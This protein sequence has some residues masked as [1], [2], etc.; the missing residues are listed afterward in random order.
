MKAIDQT[1]AVTLD[2]DWA[3]DFAIDFVADQLI[4]FHIPATWFVTHN[5]PAVE[6]LRSHSELFEL[7]IHPNFE[8]GS[9]HGQNTPEIL[10]HCQQLVPD[11]KCVR[12]HGLMQSTRLLESILAQT[13]LTVD[14]TLFLPRTPAVRPVNYRLRGRTLTQIPFVW[15]D[16]FEMEAELPDWQPESVLEIGSGLKVFNFHP[17][18]IF[19]NSPDPL[20]YCDLKASTNCLCNLREE[21]TNS[22]VHRGE[23][24]GKCF[25]RLLAHIAAS[26]CGAKMCDI[27]RT[28]DESKSSSARNRRP[29]SPQSN[30]PTSAKTVSYGDASWK[31]ELFAAQD[32]NVPQISGIRHKQNFQAGGRAYRI[33]TGAGQLVPTASE[34]SADR[35]DTPHYRVWIDRMVARLPQD[36][37]VADLSCGDGRM[38]SLLL[39]AG[40]NRILAQDSSESKLQRL[41]D[42]LSSSE[43]DR[44]HLVRGCVTETALRPGIADAVVMTEVANTL[45]DP[46]CAYTH[47]AQWL[48]PGGLALISNVAVESYVMHA[49]LN[50]DWDQVRRVVEEHR[51]VDTVG[52]QPVEVLLYPPHRMREDAAAAGLEVRDEGSITGSAAVLL[53]ALHRAGVLGEESDP[54]LRAAADRVPH[55]PRLWIDLLQKP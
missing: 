31:V 50:E 24:A 14:C 20:A 41:W 10:S 19:L 52:G 28:W 6:R 9:T 18:H 51:Y 33:D 21:G 15:Q 44:V 46:Q 32:G 48:K 45:A 16:D 36:A 39:A 35:Y 22:F 27:A 11:A 5:S 29:K 1:I 38:I 40:V 30:V 47:A 7:G 8:P 23:G 42:A 12:M 53:H 34:L 26:D 55:L 25:E 17:M 3:P 43:R 2:I 54:L 13:E 4:R 37:V 49:L